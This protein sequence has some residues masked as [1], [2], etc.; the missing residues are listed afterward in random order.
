MF[1]ELIF[2]NR[3]DTMLSKSSGYKIILIQHEDVWKDNWITLTMA[4][5]KKQNKN[6]NNPEDCAVRISY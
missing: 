1:T 6:P 3:D 2:T 5:S 4:N